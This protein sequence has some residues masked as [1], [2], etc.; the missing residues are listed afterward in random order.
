MRRDSDLAEQIMWEMLHATGIVPLSVH[1]SFI[2]PVSQ[3]GKMKEAME[4]AFPCGNTGQKSLVE[5]A[6]NFETGHVF[7]NSTETLETLTQDGKESGP[8]TGGLVCGPVV[9][10]GGSVELE[11]RGL[12]G[13]LM[14]HV[15][16]VIKK[17]LDEH[18]A[19]MRPTKIV[20]EMVAKLSPEVRMLALGLKL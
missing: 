11:E 14:S 10:V 6:P 20:L 12:G 1:D 13:G 9:G 17:Q 16:G 18:E 3:K 5:T 2:V 19:R 7:E 4:N 8:G 15:A